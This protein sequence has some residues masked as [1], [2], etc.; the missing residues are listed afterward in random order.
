MS[1]RRS[2]V[3]F[4]VSQVLA[5]ALA[6]IA[7]VISA[8]WLG[9]SA[10]GLVSLATT[11]GQVGAVL[12]SLGAGTGLTVL[13]SRREMSLGSAATIALGVAVLAT[14]LALGV[15]PVM[16]PAYGDPRALVV[17]WLPV[18]VMA[19]VLSNLQS[20]LAVGADRFGSSVANSA[21]TGVLMAAGYAAYWRFGEPTV[22]NALL[23]WTVSQ[24]CG[25]LVG[26]T[27]LLKG[28]RFRA[29]R[30]TGLGELFRLSAAAIPASILSVA[31]TR[32]DILLLGL[33][34]PVA[35]VGRYAIAGLG[36]MVLGI[37]P[38]AVGQSLASRYGTDRDAAIRL[39]RRG[40]LVGFIIAG[41]TGVLAALAMFP[42]E[43]LVLGS[44]YR[45]TAQMFVLMVPGAVCFS[46]F[47][48]S[49]TYFS[50]VL[51]RPELAGRAAGVSLA[52]DMVLL[53]LLAPSFGGYGAAVASTV[54]Y[55]LGAAV[56]VWLLRVEFRF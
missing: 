47:Q 4:G 54:A 53:A 30:L 14:F 55:T 7:T 40:A 11:A 38:S 46:I 16:R 17:T 33:L 41:G 22:G 8:A 23:V 39:L 3:L 36:V 34:A 37:G 56:T 5:L 29:V 21:V 25:D 48:S 49:L 6:A 1:I 20:S 45:G 9:S 26:W 44:S 52:V 42:F 35:D 10:R 31:N 27:A 19:Y 32:A 43:A 28:V 24:L 2:A 50:V 51:K 18:T 13:V 15:Q 12:F